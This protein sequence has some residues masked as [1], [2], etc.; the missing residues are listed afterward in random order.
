MKITRS[1][2]INRNG[3]ALVVT[4]SLMVL[5]TVIAVGLLTL[6]AISIRSAANGS[7]QAEAQANARLALMLAI[8]ELQK[9]MGPDMRVSAESAIFD[10]DQSTEAIDGVAQ[11]HWLASYNSWGDWL[12]NTYT[13]P[14]TSSPLKIG[15][16]YTPKRDRMFRRW[17]LSLP[18]GN[19]TNIGALSS[20]PS[21]TDPNWVVMVGPGSLGT[22]AQADKLTR[23]YLTKVG[24]TGKSAWWIGPENHKARINMAKKPRTLS[25]DEWQTAQG[26][27]AEVGVGSL[28]GLTSLDANDKIGDKLQTL[29]TL[30]PALGPLASTNPPPPDPVKERFFDLTAQSQGVIASVRGTGCRTKKLVR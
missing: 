17:L 9:E 24:K 3:F 10:T 29:Q 23:A 30:R 7:A 25:T 4:L 15:D 8:G 6:S 26:D 13:P 19:E 22:S 12:N 1:E 27:T 14:G 20:L 2:R 18:V 11:S 5:L 21:A 28:S 16:T